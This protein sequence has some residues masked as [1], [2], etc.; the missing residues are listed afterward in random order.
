M[1]WFQN[2]DYSCFLSKA[3]ISFCSGDLDISIPK[4]GMEELEVVL[5]QAL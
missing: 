3:D 5:K 2:P 4:I 1:S